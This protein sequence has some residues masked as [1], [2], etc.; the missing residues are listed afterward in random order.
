MVE[1]D[2]IL[3]DALSDLLAADTRYGPVVD[4]A[5]AVRGV[6]SLEAVGHALAAPSSHVPTASELARESAEAGE[7]RAPDD[8]VGLEGAEARPS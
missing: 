6:L 1:L 5:G 4:E 2:D 8:G 7:R 3:R